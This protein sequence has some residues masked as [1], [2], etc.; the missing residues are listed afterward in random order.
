MEFE[1]ISSPLTPSPLTPS[2]LPHSS[3]DAPD[4]LHRLTALFDATSVSVVQQGHAIGALQVRDVM[5]ER[6]VE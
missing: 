3:A 6:V 4:E 5:L 2:F 1:V